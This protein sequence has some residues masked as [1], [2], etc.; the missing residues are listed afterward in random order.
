MH[1]NFIN[2]LLGWWRSEEK[3]FA[4]STIFILIIFSL[5][6]VYIN[7]LFSEWSNSFFSAIETKDSAKAVKYSLLFFPLLIS[8]ILSFVVTRYLGFWIS[9]RW[10]NWL[11]KNFIDKWLAEK[12]YYKIASKT[13]MLD[14]PDQR[15][16]SDISSV[17]SLTIDMLITV[18]NSLVTYITFTIMLWQFSGKLIFMIGQNKIS[19]PGILVYVSTLYSLIGLYATFKIGKPLIGLNQ[20]KEK[21][22][23][24]FRF[25]MMRI[26]ERREEVAT[27]GGEVIE[28]SLLKEKFAQIY[29][30]TKD[31]LLKSVRL[32]IFQN[33]LVNIQLFIPLFFVIPSFFLGV[34][35][36]G[37]MMQIKTI[38]IG[39]TDAFT[40]ISLM[41]G[42]YADL[43]AS[44]KRLHY[45]FEL[46]NNNK[47]RVLTSSENKLSIK[48]L[49]INIGNQDE[50]NSHVVKVESL[51]FEPNCRTQILAPSGYGKTS[52]IRVLCG[53]SKFF[54]AS[55]LQVPDSVLFI[56]QKPYMLISTLKTSVCYP[57]ESYDDAEIIK[58]MQQCKLEHLI[59]KLE[60]VDD[61]Q[62]KLSG[63]ELQ[64][65]N[66]VRALLKK[67]KW[68]IMDEPI[69]NMDA[70]LGQEICGL[71]SKELKNTSI[72]IFSHQR[73]EGYKLEILNEENTSGGSCA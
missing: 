61:Y 9:F 26:F 51:S 34:V 55:E 14:N 39:A 16:A 40:D 44:Y 62:N 30:N 27:L 70:K 4:W 18:F 22:E 19:I 3:F 64:R 48:N 38:F 31:I 42:K 29:L 45:F 41:F 8:I 59:G 36:L 57:A 25:S 7:I 33:F 10:R 56:P 2:Y 43:M 54:N 24:N 66:F 71:I 46:L 6:S 5:A 11:T 21:L 23:A 58:A 53:L 37:V 35:T 67:P 12:N 50:N 20:N 49:Q 73:I 32:G 52:I 72:I 13:D 68:L 1:K 69:S 28:N 63:G 60:I 15:I 47:A 17:T 65:V